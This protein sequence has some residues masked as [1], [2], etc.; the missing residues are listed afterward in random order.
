MCNDIVKISLRAGM[1]NVMLSQCDCDC[2]ER[3]D[4]VRHQFNDD[5]LRDDDCDDDLKNARH[6]MSNRFDDVMSCDARNVASRAS[7]RRYATFSTT[8]FLRDARFA[9]R[10][11]FARYF[12]SKR[13]RIKT[14]SFASNVHAF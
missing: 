3:C 10:S 2:V 13:D 4:D 5:E 14:Y 12:A 1:F 11:F 9:T 6:D 8:T 7:Q